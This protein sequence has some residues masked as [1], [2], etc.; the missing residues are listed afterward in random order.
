MWNTTTQLSLK[1]Q[2]NQ[3]S[4]NFVWWTLK[5]PTISCTIGFGLLNTF[6]S[7]MWWLSTPS[8]IL[9]A[10]VSFLKFT[11]PSTTY[12]FLY[13][14]FLVNLRNIAA[15]YDCRNFLSNSYNKQGLICLF[16]LCMLHLRFIYLSF[17]RLL[18]LWDTIHL[19]A[20]H[21]HVWLIDDLSCYNVM[22]NVNF[23]ANLHTQKR[24]EL[25]HLPNINA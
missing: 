13:C 8:L 21:P 11:K 3:P 5:V 22:Y 12:T 7:N 17:F 10:F 24:V 4:L 16:L 20:G 15:C 6:F 2:L 1:N 19:Y 14:I 25:L 9:A 18:T 23:I